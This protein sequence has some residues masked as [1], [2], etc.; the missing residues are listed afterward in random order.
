MS[1][2]KKRKSSKRNTR[3]ARRLSLQPLQSRQ[4]MAGDIDFNSNTGV[5]TITGEGFN[6]QVEV[7][8]EGDEVEV[9]LQSQRSNGSF[10]RSRQDED[11]EDVRQI[12][13]NGFGGDDSFD[14][15]QGTLDSGLSVANIDIVF[16][17]GAGNDTMNNNSSIR[18]LAYGGDG[19]D[20]LIGGKARDFIFGE[21]G[22]DELLGSKR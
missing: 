6:D 17:A 12:V 9:E 1:V 10:D 20:S 16:N 5:L 15:T 22:R 19:N 11:I 7:R 13:F 14:I 21:A 3:R 18:S 8:V 2:S 4:L